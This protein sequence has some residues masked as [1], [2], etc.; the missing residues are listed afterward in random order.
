MSGSWKSLLIQNN[1]NVGVGVGTL[2][3]SHSLMRLQSSGYSNKHHD[4]RPC[5]S[6]KIVCRWQA[7]CRAGHKASKTK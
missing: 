7:N 4:E 3:G 6:R 5:L 1:K 2:G